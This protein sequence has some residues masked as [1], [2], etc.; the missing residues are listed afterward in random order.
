MRGCP[1]AAKN[2]WP[3]PF[4]AALL[5]LVGLMLIGSR[6]DERALSLPRAPAPDAGSSQQGSP[7]PLRRRGGNRGQDATSPSEIP[8]K[9]WWDILRRTASQASE[10]RLLTEAAG[11]TFYALLALFPALTALV[12]LYGLVADVGDVSRHLSDLSGVIPGGGMQIVEEQVRRVAEQ[13]NGKLG[14]G[15]VMGLAVSLWSANGATK[16]VFDTLNLIYE[17]KEQRSFLKRTAVTLGFTIGAILF[18]LLAIGAV[19]ALPV[20]L[21]FVGLGPVADFLLRFA[22]WPIM[23]V[24]IA[25]LLAVMFRYGPSR[26]SAKW[27]W[28]SW[29][30]GFS[31]VFWLIGSAGFSF[32][33]ENFASYNETYGSLGAAIGFMTWIWISAAI[34]LAGAEL[35]AEMER[36]TGRDTTTGPEQPMGSR[37]ATVA[38]TSATNKS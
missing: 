20:V 15:L 8:A 34:V 12:S 37:G 29:G 14:F 6:Q 33:V 3:S 10:D 7:S 18:V 9:G 4:L 36:Q 38:D 30:G 26:D 24:V 17:E 19:V 13:G 5:A 21:K 25:V 27:R 35:D 11:I 1:V 28:V 32:Y 22:R 23:L 31:A 2:D 16:A